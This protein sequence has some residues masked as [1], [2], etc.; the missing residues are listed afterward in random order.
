MTEADELR[1]E[2]RRLRHEV[3]QKQRRENDMAKKLE[4]YQRQAMRR[5]YELDAA[6]TLAQSLCL[7]RKELAELGRELLRTFGETP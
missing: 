1:D 6:R 5:A 2:V 3:S 4:L 7:P